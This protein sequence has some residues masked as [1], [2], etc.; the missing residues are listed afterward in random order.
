[1]HPNAV[2]IGSGIVFV[3]STSFTA[4]AL[5]IA[6]LEQKARREIPERYALTQYKHTF[7][8]VASYMALQCIIGGLTGLIVGIAHKARGLFVAGACLAIIPIYSIAVI[9]PVNKQ[10]GH[11]KLTE[12]STEAE[13]RQVRNLFATWNKMHFVRVALGAGAMA[14]LLACGHKK[15]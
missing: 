7:R 4:T 8:S 10:L 6:T 15:H 13:N 9:G 5:Y 11:S 2:C 1:M 12:T 14:A 3:L